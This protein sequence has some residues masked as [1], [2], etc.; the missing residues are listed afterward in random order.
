[1]LG[2]TGR[3]VAIGRSD[4]TTQLYTDVQRQDGKPNPSEKGSWPIREPRTRAGHGCNR[5]YPLSRT[6]QTGRGVSVGCPARSPSRMPQRGNGMKPMAPNP[7]GVAALSAEVTVANARSRLRTCR[8][9]FRAI[10]TPTPMIRAEVT[11]PNAI[12]RPVADAPTGQW[13]EAQGC[14]VRAA[15]LG[16]ASPHRPNPNGVPALSAGHRTIPQCPRRGDCRQREEPAANLSY[17]LQSDTDTDSD[18]T[19]RGACPQREQRFPTAAGSRETMWLS[20]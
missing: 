1:M 6:R 10:P 16:W 14:G 18:D 3:H 12:V 5:P 13:N 15:T 7:N 9:G 2:P 11:V 19:G 8:T 17:G 4:G 20:R